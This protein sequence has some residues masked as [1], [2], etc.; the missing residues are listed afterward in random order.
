MAL[1]RIDEFIARL[2]PLTRQ[3]DIKALCYLEL[4]Y[5]RRELEIKPIIGESGYPVSCTGD[6]R[7]LKTQVSQYRKAIESLELTP[8]NSITEIKLG[9]KIQYHKALKYFNL[10]DY[11]KVDVNQRD[12]NRV[13]KD[14]SNRP[15]FN[16]VEVIKKAL[17]LLDSG[18]YISKVA[19]LYLLTGRR[20]EEILVT[21]KIDKTGLTCDLTKSN[22]LDQWLQDGIFFG[23]FSG[24]VKTKKNE[25]IPYKIPLLAPIETIKNAIEWLRV[26]KPQDPNKRPSG[27]KEL[28]LKVRKEYS[29]ILPIPSGKE[30]YLSPHNLRSAYCAICWQLYRC[31]GVNC[32]EDLFVKAIM[33]HTEDSLESAQSY[34]DYELKQDDQIA[35]LDYW[36]SLQMRD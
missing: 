32:T 11:E 19:G 10:A 15:S 24:Q 16:A 8:K 17:E 28:G 14:K 35:L 7:R 4:D 3:D 5:L 1:A 27:S 18:S 9:Q 33:G 26:N 25:A 34:L 22:S 36:E 20:H 31:E 21:G 30:L 29:D 23:L 12:R 2:Q 6:A 13:T